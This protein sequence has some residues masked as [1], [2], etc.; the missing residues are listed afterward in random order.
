[1]KRPGEELKAEKV[2]QCKDQTYGDFI[3]FPV[4]S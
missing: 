2:H 1:M 3:M 4:Q